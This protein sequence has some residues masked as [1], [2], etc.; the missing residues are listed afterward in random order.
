MYKKHIPDT[1][2]SMC[3]ET[4][5]QYCI[6]IYPTFTFLFIYFTYMYICVYIQYMYVY[7]MHGKKMYLDC[8]K[9][10][11]KAQIFFET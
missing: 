2:T 11:I 4:H 6:P 9:A 7:Y 5:I 3:T 1:H 10:D 8:G